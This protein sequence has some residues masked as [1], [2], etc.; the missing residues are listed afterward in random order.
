MSELT[1]NTDSEMN[2][3][4]AKKFSITSLG[5]FP[6]MLVRE[7][8]E[9]KTAFVIVPL[10]ISTLMVMATLV[11]MMTANDLEHVL[12]IDADEIQYL[13]DKFEQIKADPERFNEVKMALKVAAG[14]ISGWMVFLL[15]P[16]VVV[17]PLLNSLYDE[18]QERSYL[19]WKS[20]PVSDAM[21]VA[22]KFVFITLIGP[23]IL[24]AIAALLGLTQLILLTPFIWSQVN[25]E[26]VGILWQYMPVLSVW[27]T[28]ASFYLLLWMWVLPILA[29]FMLASSYAPKA[30]LMF[31][32]VP[33]AAIA[34]LEQIIDTGHS[35][36]AEAI[37]SRFEMMGEMIENAVD[38][39]A[40]DLDVYAPTMGDAFSAI[41]YGLAEPAWWMGTATAGAFLAGAIY[42]R[43][44]RS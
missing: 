24:F 3:S 35:Y 44:Y 11:S 32:I 27:F 7:F 20:M 37:G 28:I 10:V 6:A 8:H 17:F 33:P 25:G 1:N 5:K 42:I 36:M 34:I 26:V 9:H 41:G 38:S 4:A 18:R 29:W 19:F 22:A 43:K 23:F 13:S 30:P 12:S 2:T 14:M 21:E 15:L 40:W 16:F 31:A 39:N